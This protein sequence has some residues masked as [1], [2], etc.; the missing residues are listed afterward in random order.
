MSQPAFEEIDVNKT[1][2]EMWNQEMS[3]KYIAAV[4][5]VPLDTVYDVIESSFTEP[6]SE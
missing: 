1:I 2:V 5:Y 6:T 3:P 4:L